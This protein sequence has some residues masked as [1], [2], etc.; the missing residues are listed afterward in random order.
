M[1][2]ALERK[3]LIDQ[4]IKVLVPDWSLAPVVEAL[5]ALRGIA[6]AVAHRFD[7]RH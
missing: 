5:Q 7:H 6:L 2:Q 3:D 4:Q 1:D